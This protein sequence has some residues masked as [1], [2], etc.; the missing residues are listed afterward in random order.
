MQLRDADRGAL[1]AIPEAALPADTARIAF[2]AEFLDF[3]STA[4][5]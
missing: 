5:P 2:G 4:V 3:P 1:A